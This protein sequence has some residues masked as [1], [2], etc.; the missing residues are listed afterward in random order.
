MVQRLELQS[1]LEEIS[2]NV[3]FQP[4]ENVKMQ[5]PCIVY[6]RSVA[7]TRFGDNVPLL[8]WMRYE[9]T[10][11]DRDPDSALLDPVKDLP[12]CIFNRHFVAQDLNHDVFNLYWKGMSA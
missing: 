6:K 9:V 10:I 11:I 5:Y 2:E 12:M 1:L 8:N 7:E 3:Y 4:P